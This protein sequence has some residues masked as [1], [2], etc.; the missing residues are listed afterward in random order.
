MEELKITIAAKSYT[1]NIDKAKREHYL[2]AER[3]VNSTITKIQKMNFE[4]Y[5]LH[6]AIALTAF[7][8]AVSN[9]E[10]KQQSEVEP[11]E[12]KTLK[13]LNQKIEEYLNN[14]SNE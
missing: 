3:R 13:E 14:P 4:G 11:E 5:N 9:I 7:D 8:F 1:L 2:L 10:L 6:D 12:V